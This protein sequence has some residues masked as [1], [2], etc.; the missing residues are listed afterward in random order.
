MTFGWAD[1]GV[2]PFRFNPNDRKLSEKSSCS[3]RPLRGQAQLLSFRRFAS[4]ITQNCRTRT[5]AH[6]QRRPNQRP[7]KTHWRRREN[8]VRILFGPPTRSSIGSTAQPKSAAPD[9][10]IPSTR[11]TDG[12][13]KEGLKLSA[14]S[15][16]NHNSNQEAR[17][18]AT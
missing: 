4:G 14:G 10:E 18:T 15:T 12:F 2:R 7:R 6:W 3:V 17:H 11:S 13:S 1:P 9:F 5:S 16:G 8:R